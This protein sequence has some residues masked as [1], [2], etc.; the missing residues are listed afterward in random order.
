M[1][2]GH[3]QALSEDRKMKQYKKKKKRTPHKILF[4]IKR[5]FSQKLLLR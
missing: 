1:I 5:C 4:K 2:T 3:Y